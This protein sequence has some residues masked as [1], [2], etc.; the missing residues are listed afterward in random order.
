M[1]SACCPKMLNMGWNPQQQPKGSE[2]AGLSLAP[3]RRLQS[4]PMSC[5]FQAVYN[6][7]QMKIKYAFSPDPCHPDVVSVNFNNQLSEWQKIRKSCKKPPEG[8]EGTFPGEQLGCL[9]LS[10]RRT[11]KVRKFDFSSSETFPSTSQLGRPL[12]ALAC[13]AIY[14]TVILEDEEDPTHMVPL[15]FLKEIQLGEELSQKSG[16]YQWVNHARKGL[17]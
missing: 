12:W 16:Q 3:S 15:K 11:L 6:E 13:S 8:G 1:G 7:R 5:S 9:G 17:A 14:H 4:G 2:W 10:T